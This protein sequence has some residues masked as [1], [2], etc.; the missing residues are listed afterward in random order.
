MVWRASPSRRVWQGG[1]MLS[2]DRGVANSRGL[3]H[4]ALHTSH[5]DKR[6]G[7]AKD[8]SMLEVL[9]QCLESPYFTLVTLRSTPL[10]LAIPKMPQTKRSLDVLIVGAGLGGLAAG[11]A[12]QT[13]GHRVTII[14]STPEFK[15]VCCPRSAAVASINNESAHRK[16]YRPVRVYGCRQI[17]AGC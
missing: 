7:H 3:Q 13:D 10:H 2:D 9:E 1:A 4:P 15:E 11:L 16:R 12:L 17:P 8:Q 14:D 6:K 5:Q